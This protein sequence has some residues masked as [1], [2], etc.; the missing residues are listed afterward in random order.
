MGE[1]LA[2]MINTNSNQQ[3]KNKSQLIIRNSLWVDAALRYYRFL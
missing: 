3:V 1:I 2:D